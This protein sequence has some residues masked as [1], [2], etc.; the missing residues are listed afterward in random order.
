MQWSAYRQAAIMTRRELSLI[1]QPHR[2]T[3]SPGHGGPG[4]SIQHRLEVFTMK[5]FLILGYGVACYLVFFTTFLYAIGF[6]GN[7]GVP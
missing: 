6:V 7:I 4:V 5:R 1:V 2:W 3:R